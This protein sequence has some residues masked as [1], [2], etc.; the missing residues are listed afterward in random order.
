MSLE[1]A[2]IA[3]TSDA[4][5]MSKPDSRGYPFARPPRPIAIWRSARSFMSSARR[6]PTRS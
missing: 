4:A 3:M 1:T 2:M 5:V 6:Q